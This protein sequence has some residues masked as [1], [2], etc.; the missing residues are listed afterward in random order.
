M[1]AAALLRT[2]AFAAIALLRTRSGA[3]FAWHFLALLARF[4]KADSNSLL[5]AVYLA[6]LTAWAAA[7][8]AALVTLHLAFDILRCTL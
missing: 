4:R 5:T 3:L 2:P 7:R 8:R 6:A 1:F